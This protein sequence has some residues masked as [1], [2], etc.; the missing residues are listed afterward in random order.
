MLTACLPAWTFERLAELAAATG[1][2]ALEVAV[3]PVV[4]GREFEAGHLPV[5]TFTD[6]DEARVRAV[7]DR[8]GLTISALAYYENNLHP[9]PPRRVAVHE[10]VQH[11]VDVAERLGIA[12]VGTFIG[13]DN[14]KTVVENQREAERVLP[15]LVDYAGERGVRLVVEN[16]PMEG[17]HPDGYPGNIAY[18]PELWS[19][20]TGL[21]LYLNWDP[22]HL[23]GLGIEP[24]ATIAPFAPFIAH[25]QAKD[26]EV[27][28]R[29]RNTFGWFGR[30]DRSADP[31]DSGWWRFRVPGRGQVDWRGVVDRLYEVGFDGTISVEHEDPLWSG[32]DERVVEGL[33]IAQRTLRPLIA[34]E[35]PRGDRRGAPQVQAGP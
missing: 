16:C 17:W 33:R 22:S 29:A 26:M 28:P 12:Y 23:V 11:A 27:D 6:E 20:L 1:Y 30:T 5:A 32:S 25:A 14:G 24:V 21:G 34:Q 7:L 13:R 3:W 18:S 8:T 9:D 19:W 15:A 35:S 31:W 2:D 10:H 4:G